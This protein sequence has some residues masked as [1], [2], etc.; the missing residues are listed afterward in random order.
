MNDHLDHVALDFFRDGR[1]IRTLVLETSDIDVVDVC[2][3]LPND[4]TRVPLFSTSLEESSIKLLELD[5]ETV[6]LRPEDL[7]RELVVRGVDMLLD[8]EGLLDGL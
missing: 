7:A 3:F 6:V 1:D 5:L 4:M 8:L 2:S